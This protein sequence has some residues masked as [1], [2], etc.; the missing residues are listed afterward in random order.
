MQLCIDE[1]QP[2]SVL[3]AGCEIR[4]VNDQPALWAESLE[5]AFPAGDDDGED[6][7]QFSIVSDYI[8]YHQRAMANVTVPET[9]TP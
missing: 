3:P 6:T 7:V 5:A 2:S 1:W 9:R 4:A 8:R